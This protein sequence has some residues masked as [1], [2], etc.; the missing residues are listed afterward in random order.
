M[1][2]RDTL[3]TGTDPDDDP[4]RDLLTPQRAIVDRISDT[5]DEVFGVVYGATVREAISGSVAHPGNDTL[6]RLVTFLE[7]VPR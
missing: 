2:P 4:E 5:H 7:E 3:F 1:T 6:E